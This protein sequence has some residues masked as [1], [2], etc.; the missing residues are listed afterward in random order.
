M[1]LTAIEQ[2][3]LAGVAQMIL[4]LLHHG[5]YKQVLAEGGVMPAGN[6]C[7]YSEQITHC[8]CLDFRRAQAVGTVKVLP[9]LAVVT[10]N[11]N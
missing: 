8:I 7:L 1:M 3:Q 11:N 10:D 5:A 4:R 6:W 9:P 2:D